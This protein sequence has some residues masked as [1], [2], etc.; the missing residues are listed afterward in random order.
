[1]HSISK[2][3]YLES[4]GIA[5]ASASFGAKSSLKAARNKSAQEKLNKGRGV[6]SGYSSRILFKCYILSVLGEHERLVREREELLSAGIY[7]DDDPLIMELNEQIRKLE[8]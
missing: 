3:N 8:A 6:M 1:M 2:K 5:S 4:P 7:E